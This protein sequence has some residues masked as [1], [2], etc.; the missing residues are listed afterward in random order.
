MLTIFCCAHRPFQFINNDWIR[1]IGIGGLDVEGGF[2]DKV[3]KNVAELNPFFNELTAHYWVRHNE[4]KEFVG[5]CH[6]R[7]WLSFVPLNTDTTPEVLAPSK[8][9]IDFLTS[10]GQR[11]HCAKL[12]KTY[13]I[14]APR[15]MYFLL[16]IKS[17]Y[18]MA[19]LPQD[20]WDIFT[21]AIAVL[22][23]KYFA[24][25]AHFDH[26]QFAY[27][28]NIYV[29]RW[30]IFCAYFDELFPVL[31]YA[32][33]RLGEKYANTP[34]VKRFCGYLGER[35]FNLWVFCNQPKIHELPCVMLPD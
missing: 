13:D 11:D 3:G 25:L 30:E 4:P 32:Y 23:P 24:N 29:T 7:R 6:Y 9:F 27:M 1:T 8:D 20:T 19:D 10:D 21:E 33:D 17:Q 31:M 22:Q 35:Y 28:R 15:R 14:L 5:F 34:H 12:L 16:G 26:A 18:L 2:T